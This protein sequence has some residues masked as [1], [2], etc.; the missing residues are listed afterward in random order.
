MIA[1]TK[2]VQDILNELEGSGQVKSVQDIMNAVYATGASGAAAIAA[3]ESAIGALEASN[4]SAALGAMLHG[5][6]T[7]TIGGDGIPTRTVTIQFK[8]I[9]NTNIA[10]QALSRLWLS[11]DPAGTPYSSAAYV[12]V[13]VTTGAILKTITN[14]K[15]YFIVSNATGVILLAL[16]GQPGN[17]LYVNVELNGRVY[18][19]AK[20]DFP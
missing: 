12:I 1:N 13:T 16:S 18:S 4:L 19:S 10:F 14:K 9:K 8:D 7:L 17:E 3:L 15:D 20:V 6:P 2:S 11:D 5:A